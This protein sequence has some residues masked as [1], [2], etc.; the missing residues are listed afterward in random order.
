MNLKPNTTLQSGKYRIIR[1][2]GQGG[3]GITYLAEHTLLDKLV[4]IKEFFPKDFCGRVGDTSSLYIYSPNQKELVVKLKR[5]FMKEAKNIAKL[6][7]PN[8]IKIHD[9]FEENNTAYYVMDYIEGENLSENLKKNGPLPTRTAISYINKIGDAL[10][11]IHSHNMTHFDVKPAN[12][13]IRKKD[14]NPIL[15]DFGFSKQFNNNS[16]AT[17]TLLQGVS[18][19]FSAIEMYSPGAIESFSPQTDIY[20]LGATLLFLLTGKIPPPATELA[21]KG[22][23]IPSYVNSKCANII[24]VAMSVKPEFR[25]KDIKKLIHPLVTSKP[26]RPPK[27]KQ[28]DVFRILGLLSIAAGIL[29]AIFLAFFIGNNNSCSTSPKPNVTLDTI[30]DNRFLISM[31]NDHYGNAEYWGYIYVANDSVLY[32]PDFIKPG[33]VLKIPDLSQYNVSPENPEDIT[34]ARNLNQQIYKKFHTYINRPTDDP[35]IVP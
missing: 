30:T 21:T 28:K 3:F 16:E 26:T 22:L 27:D 10:A 9:S 12:I 8:I 17:S 31:A 1:V 33:T 2:L 13:I 29:I 15:I 23:F 5:R 34:K 24:K 35:I 11:Y 14:S 6:D 20:S 19:G 7:H 4:A 18:Q 32:H 25:E